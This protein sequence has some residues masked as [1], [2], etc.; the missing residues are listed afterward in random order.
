MVASS[1]YVST[2]SR[3]VSVKIDVKSVQKSTG[4]K[5]G[6]A[7]FEADKIAEI[8]I[9]DLRSASAGYL[10]SGNCYHRVLSKRAKKTENRAIKICVRCGYKYEKDWG[11]FGKSD[12]FY[13]KADELRVKYN[14]VQTCALTHEYMQRFIIDVCNELDSGSKEIRFSANMYENYIQHRNN[15]DWLKEY[16]A[17]FKAK[18]T[19]KIALI[20]QLAEERMKVATN[21]DPAHHLE[22][23]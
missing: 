21:K 10:Q 1:E 23:T 13:D 14:L 22:D 5:S 16:H 11:D 12:E 15:I 17:K 9:V 20:Q 7:Y 2:V 3:N 4:E 6:N 19:Q 18:L 8:E